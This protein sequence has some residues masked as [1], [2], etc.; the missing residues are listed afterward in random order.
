M[1]LEAPAPWCKTCNKALQFLSSI[2]ITSVYS[3]LYTP[4]SC[5]SAQRWNRNSTVNPMTFNLAYRCCI[6]FTIETL[7][8]KTTWYHLYIFSL[9]EE[10]KLAYGLATLQT[11]PCA[12]LT[13]ASTHCL[14]TSLLLPLGLHAANPHYA[15]ALTMGLSFL[16]HGNSDLTL[17]SLCQTH[18]HSGFSHWCFWGPTVHY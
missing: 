2:Y 18:K 11:H 5:K 6:F 7:S 16:T 17:Q 1:W 9:Q 12:P 3:N 13:P 14:G 4:Y 8:Y 10:A 15:M